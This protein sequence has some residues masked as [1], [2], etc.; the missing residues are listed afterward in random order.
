MKILV[1]ALSG[2]GDALM[3]S[4]S[5][6]KLAEEFPRARIDALVMYKG[7]RDI[8]SNYPQ[9]SWI[10]YFDFINSPAF[11]SLKFVLGLRRKYDIT[12]NVYPANRKEYNLISWLIG[13][14][15]RAAVRYLRRD[16][17]E[18][19]FLNNVRV[20]EN[21]SFHNVKE[22]LL[23]CEKLS[24]I[25]SGPEI[26][27]QMIFKD[28][29]IDYARNFLA[30][31]SIRTGD[32]VIGFHPGCSALKNHDKRRWEK[33]KFSAL[34]RKLIDDHGTKI[35]IFGGNDEEYLKNSIVTEVNSPN[36]I[37]VVTANL[38]QTAAV[39]RRCNLFVTNDS[40]LMHVASALKLKIVAIIG[41]TNKNYI[42]PWQ[43]DYQIVSLNLECSPCFHYSPKP[44]NCSRTDLKFKCIKDLSVDR[45]Y[46]IVSGRIKQIV[47][48]SRI[49]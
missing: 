39:M 35:L 15:R 8:Y 14:K 41:P 22:N 5:L 3:F 19:G 13:A 31:Q 40:S 12:I 48:N 44:L 10:H 6:V 9:F 32:L 20:R 30:G 18:L 11:N 2:I 38:I 36:V 43:T 23:L 29:D 21:D 42:H 46:E 37:P 28:E 27:L 33:S 47:E 16:F 24:G 25:V 26:S 7:V 49:D 1:I 17:V 34:A 4:P 45:V